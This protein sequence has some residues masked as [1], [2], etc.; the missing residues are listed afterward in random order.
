MKKYIYTFAFFACAILI[1]RHVVSDLKQEERIW[2][3]EQQ[4]ES[5][6]KESLRHSDDARKSTAERDS[7]NKDYWQRENDSRKATRITNKTE[8]RVE[9]K[10]KHAFDTLK[11]ATPIILELNTI[12]SATLTKIPG[13]GAKSASM[14]IRYREQLGGFVSPYQIGEKLVWESAQEK[15]DEWCRMWMKADTALVRK[16]NVN[17]AEFREI[18]RHPYVSFE[19]TKALV[20]YRDKHKRIS[21]EEVLYMLEEFTEDDIARLKPYLSY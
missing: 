10:A 6:R 17:E 11:F 8:R 1:S 15:M 7:E 4:M 20:N 19:Q 2:A 13:I 16:L 5:L 9:R 21:G 3:L 14:I 18:L 12:D